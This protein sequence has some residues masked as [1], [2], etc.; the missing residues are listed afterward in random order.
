M[1]VK[2]WGPEVDIKISGRES[3]DWESLKGDFVAVSTQRQVN[4]PAGAWALTL[5]SRRDKQGRT[6]AKRIR[7]MDYVEI[8]FGRHKKRG[9]K[10]QMIMRA[11]VDQVT[12]TIGISAEG[13]PQ[14]QITVSGKDLGKL[15]LIKQIFILPAL[16]TQSFLAESI[17]KQGMEKFIFPDL[18][19]KFLQQ[20]SQDSSMSCQKFLDAVKKFIFEATNEDVQ[21]GSGT[22]QATGVGPTNLNKNI[23]EVH[24]TAK[25]MDDLVVMPNNLQTFQGSVWNLLTAVQGRPIC[26]LIVQDYEDYPEVLWRWAPYKDKDGQIIPPASEPHSQS[27]QG[28]G[29]VEISTETI[30]SYGLSTTDADLYNFYFVEPQFGGGWQSILSPQMGAI[31]DKNPIVR[32]DLIDRYGF[33]P[34]IVPFPLL[35]FFGGATEDQK[36]D[37][38][39]SWQKVITKACDWLDKAYSNGVNLESG[40]LVIEGDERVEAGTYMKIKET[41]QEFYVES[42]RHDFMLNPPTFR[43]TLG[44]TRGLWTKNNPYPDDSGSPETGTGGTPSTTGSGDNTDITEFDPNS[45]TFG[46]QGGLIR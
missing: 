20:T 45:D 46:P 12:E 40:S 10:P 31:P 3:T 19:D 11:L 29:T 27:N 13:Q 5:I 43:T 8:R 33:K 14:R 25:D 37:M 22:P 1:V 4:A 24:F 36:K 32:K 9:E 7:P 34:L 17:T 38:E 41:G 21:S 42:V 35:N 6:W 30:V 18:W 15:L 39:Q 28:P 44:V 2:Q 16:G 26:E 23:P